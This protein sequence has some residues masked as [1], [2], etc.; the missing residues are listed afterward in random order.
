MGEYARENAGA[1]E[2]RALQAEVREK[3]RAIA[4]LRAQLDA[5]CTAPLTSGRRA[6]RTPPLVDLLPD[7]VTIV[8]EEGR[9]LYANRASLELVGAAELEGV[10]GT[11]IW[12]FVHPDEER[13]LSRHGGLRRER[14]ADFTEQRLVRLDGTVIPIETASVAVEFGGEAA[15]LITARDLRERKRAEA[16]EEET[17]TLL[18]KIFHVSPLGIMITRLEGDVV[19]AVNDAWSR[20]TGIDGGAAIGRST[21]ELRLWTDPEARR[22]FLDE[23][24]GTSA[25]YDTELGLRTAAGE[26]RRVVLHPQIIPVGGEPSLLALLDDVTERK[27]AVQALQES[28]E[29]FRMMADSAPV[30]IWLSRPGGGRSYFNQPWQEFTGRS[31]EEAFDDWLEL[32]HPDDRGRAQ[33]YL[34]ERMR[35]TDAFRHE[36]RLRRHDGIYRWFME[37]AVPRL[38]RDGRLAG[39][40]GSCVD[41]TERKE[42][43][44]KLL[45]AKDHAEEMSRLKST[46]LTNLTHEIRTPLTVILGF[47]SILRQGVREEYRRF[48][49]LIER[50][51]RRLL[52]MLDSMLDL[53]QLEAGTLRVE[54]RPY[55]LADVVE[56][57]AA[58]LRPLAKDKGL[59]LEVKLPSDGLYALLDYAIL[60]RV[61][62]NMLDNAIKFTDRG[63]IEISAQER[64]GAVALQISDTGIGIDAAYLSQ[65]FEPFS[66]E[67]TGLERTHQGSGLGLAVSKRL[68]NLMGGQIE[69]TSRKGRGSVFTIILPRP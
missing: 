43:E 60:S 16:A 57:V 47:T 4:E 9:I 6:G 59:K 19:V 53:A 30:F 66:Q 5:G 32:V 21:E 65:I 51:G 40:V 35:E 15:I 1:D 24:R 29:R 18:S 34:E 12:E 14:I 62:N 52:L 69:V 3:E 13:T 17:R 37:S 33:E 44:R 46:F 56:S 22:R 54:R 36:Y 26:E 28:E 7:A 39:F 68:V 58:A 50:S 27:R 38:D 20:L 8:D 67:S 31:G 45:E 49:D 64:D 61:L 55:N 41:I 11:S 23:C 25:L 10:L 42:T 63:K 48:V 2:V